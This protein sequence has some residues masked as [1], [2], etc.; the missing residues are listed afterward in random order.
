MSYNSTVKTAEQ[1]TKNIVSGLKSLADTEAKKSRL[2][3]TLGI[4][5]ADLLTF[6]E[7]EAHTFDNAK[8]ML[9]ELVKSVVPTEKNAKGDD[10]PDASAVTKLMSSA[11]DAVKIAM[12]LIRTDSGFI[13]GYVRNDAR[14]YVSAETFNGMSAD[15][16]KR[17]SQEVF[18]NRSQTFPMMKVGQDVIDSP[19]NLLMPTVSEMQDAYKVHFLNADIDSGYKVKSADRNKSDDLMKNPASIKKTL[20][21]VM[22]WL[23]DGGLMAIDTAETADKKDGETIKI[24]SDL[25]QKID[26]AIDENAKAN[27]EADQQAA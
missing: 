18:W 12:L 22:N 23:D 1:A 27:R 2:V 3:S 17:H 14:S 5:L 25:A 16:K 26:L 19:S 11:Q 8:S 7:A 4:S 9:R 6:S 13:A 21:A 15:A 24:L 20:Y 10:V